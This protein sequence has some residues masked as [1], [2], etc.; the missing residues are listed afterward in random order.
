MSRTRLGATVFA[1]TL[2]AAMAACASTATP[3]G[4]PPDRPVL[5][6]ETMLDHNM[7]SIPAGSFEMGSEHGRPD[8]QPARHVHLDAFAIDRYEVTNLQY[9]DFVAATGARTPVYWDGTD[10]PAGSTLHPV[11]GVSWDEA[12]AYCAWA[13]KRLPTEAEWERACRGPAARAWPWG[14]AWVAS[15]ANISMVPLADPDDAWPWLAGTAVGPAAL[16]PIGS[17][18][19]DRSG[20]GVCDLAGNAAEWVA[21]WYDPTAYTRLPAH[22]PI[23]DGPEWNHAVRGGSWLF[24]HDDTALMVHLSRCAARNA[25]HSADDPRVGFRCAASL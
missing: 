23:G 4:T 19:Q 17:H 2:T 21:D 15:A 20:D 11:V 6:L 16:L 10:A 9:A 8:E 7:A 13:G 14:D 22:N 18:P 12:A 25:S 3:T 1:A 24:R 5:D